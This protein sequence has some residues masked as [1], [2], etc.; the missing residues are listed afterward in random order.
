MLTREKNVADNEFKEF[1]ASKMTQREVLIG[2]KNLLIQE[3]KDELGRAMEEIES[4]K[5]TLYDD[6]RARYE[7]GKLCDKL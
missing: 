1:D 3:E 7:C 4:S 6:L 5:L 2:L